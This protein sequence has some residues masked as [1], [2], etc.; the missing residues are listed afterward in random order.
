MSRKTLPILIAT[1]TTVLCACTGEV[2]WS[3]PSSPPE[4]AKT[5]P[6]NVPVEAPTAQPS[7]DVVAFSTPGDL[8]IFDP[9]TGE[10]KARS[11]P[12][13]DSRPVD[14]V[15]DPWSQKLTAYHAYED[16]W[17]TILSYPLL[18]DGSLADP[19]S[20]GDVGGDARLLATRFGA[21]LFHREDDEDWTLLEGNASAHNVVAEPSPLAAFL[22]HEGR[23]HGLTCKEDE[24]L[25]VRS[26]LVDE[27]GFGDV[28][29]SLLGRPCSSAWLSDDTLFEVEDGKLV[30]RPLSDLA[31]PTR[32]T[33]DVET[34]AIVAG[35]SAPGLYLLLVNAPPRALLFA[36]TEVGMILTSSAPLP[37]VAGDTKLFTRNAIIAKQRVFAATMKGVLAFD[38]TSEGGVP[39]LVPDNQFEGKHLRGPLEHL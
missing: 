34:S 25:S 15:F 37:D 38:I 3:P 4:D 35:A 14:V 22:D 23:V 8:V 5:L 27:A 29:T 9:V 21:L 33:F 28:T 39:T 1:A 6:P 18:D 10:I 16:A 26:V 20:L 13:H 19:Q 2:A 30:A 24:G 36:A 11:A 31:L 32:S 7:Q 12:I 17:G